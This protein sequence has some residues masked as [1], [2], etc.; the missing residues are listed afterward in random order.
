MRSKT[1]SGVERS[2]GAPKNDEGG[3]YSLPPDLQRWIG[4]Y[5]AQAAPG[6]PLFP[7][8]VSR[9]AWS[10]GRLGKWWRRACEVAGVPYVSVYV[11]LK[12]SPGTAL[13]EAGT[14]S[15]EDL[16][17]VFRHRQVGMQLAYDVENDQRRDR[18]VE[19][20]VELVDRD[21]GPRPDPEDSGVPSE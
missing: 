18:G 17:A 9:A 8:P 7:N 5:R 11:A 3:T 15:R 16:Q 6:E 2:E 20:L 14:V 10:H 13:L 19:A 4:R 1:R 12:H 21:P